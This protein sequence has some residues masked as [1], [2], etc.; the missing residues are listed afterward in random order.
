MNILGRI[1]KR[2]QNGNKCRHDFLFCIVKSKNQDTN[3]N[4]TDDVTPT[5]QEMQLAETN[6]PTCQINKRKRRNNT[7]GGNITRSFSS[8]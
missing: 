2:K 7:Y 8:P 6:S 4:E 5:N 1:A 3:E